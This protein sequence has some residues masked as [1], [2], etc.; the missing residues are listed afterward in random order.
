M[1]G[2]GIYKRVGRSGGGGGG[3]GGVADHGLGGDVSLC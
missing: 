2:Q 1:K 3:G